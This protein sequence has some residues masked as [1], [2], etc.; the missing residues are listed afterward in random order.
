M[1]LTDQSL[2]IVV[3]DLFGLLR[4]A[5]GLLRM[6]AVKHKTT[7]LTIPVVFQSGKTIRKGKSLE[8]GKNSRMSVPQKLL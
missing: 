2:R 8:S 1:Q 5:I 4:Y 3:Y 7:V 6:S